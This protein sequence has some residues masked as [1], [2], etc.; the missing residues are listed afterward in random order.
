[1]DLRFFDN[2]FFGKK[3]RSLHL[4]GSE[5]SPVTY[6][7]THTHTQSSFRVSIVLFSNTRQPLSALRFFFLNDPDKMKSIL[8]RTVIYLFFLKFYHY[9][10]NFKFIQKADRMIRYAGK[11]RSIK[12]ILAVNY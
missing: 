6:I 1:M 7:H 8:H 4:N 3:I 12:I 2:Q 9:S 11:Q 5:I 10:N